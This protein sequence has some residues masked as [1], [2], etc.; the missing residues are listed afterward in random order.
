[1][2]E[3]M[4]WRIMKMPKALAAPGMYRARGWSIQ[5]K[6]SMIMNV[7]IMPRKAGNS[8][9]AITSVNSGFLKRNS[10]IANA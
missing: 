3:A 4:N 1:M 2:L 8:M 7:G 6:A 9:V 10:N 5:P